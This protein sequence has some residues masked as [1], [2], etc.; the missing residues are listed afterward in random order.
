[1]QL[2]QVP[3]TTAV[4][5]SRCALVTKA[6]APSRAS[7]GSPSFL[8]YR[9]LKSETIEPDADLS[10]IVPDEVGAPRVLD[11]RMAKRGARSPG[12][13]G[14]VGAESLNVTPAARPSSAGAFVG[15]VRGHHH[16]R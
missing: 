1:M 5:C 9:P 8:Q 2:A 12:R 15:E 14:N 13:K 3:A 4:L 7:F 11:H 10:G 6:A 16:F